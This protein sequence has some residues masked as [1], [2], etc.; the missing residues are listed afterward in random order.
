MRAMP[1]GSSFVDRASLMGMK[2]LISSVGL[3]FFGIC[4]L[5]WN[6][7]GLA[8][9]SR[10]CLFHYCLYF[11]FGQVFAREFVDEFDRALIPV[12]T[13]LDD[14]CEC[15]REL[16]RR[17]CE[18]L[19]VGAAHVGDLGRDLRVVEAPDPPASRRQVIGDGARLD[20]GPSDEL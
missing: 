4:F 15:L 11:R 3:V 12:E 14:D 18:R 17:F 5:S 8:L 6:G 20:D 19:V 7:Y 10:L 13:F 16:V 1:G 9:R 2:K